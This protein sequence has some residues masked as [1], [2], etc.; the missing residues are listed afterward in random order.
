MVMAKVHELRKGGAQVSD[1]KDDVEKVL[2]QRIIDAP[3]NE[4]KGIILLYLAQYAFMTGKR[5]EDIGV[6]E[7]KKARK[8]FKSLTDRGVPMRQINGQKLIE[9]MQRLGFEVNV[10]P[11]RRDGNRLRVRP[12]RGGKKS[13]KKGRKSM[14]KHTKKGKKTMK[15][16]M[17]KSK[18]SVRKSVRKSRKH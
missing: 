11:R 10:D 9:E 5:L 1:D 2:I 13:M 3:I 7:R 15:K 16:S 6:E 8:A 18:K 12:M 4:N 14:K 17:K